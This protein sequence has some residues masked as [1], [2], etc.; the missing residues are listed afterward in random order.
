MDFRLPSLL[1]VANDIE[2][3]GRLKALIDAN[4]FFDF[5]SDDAESE[6]SKALLAD[7]ISEFIRLFV[8][9]EL[10]NEINRAEDG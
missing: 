8:T 7:W 10:L 1:S 3:H 4:V 6:E 5:R 9:D 2:I